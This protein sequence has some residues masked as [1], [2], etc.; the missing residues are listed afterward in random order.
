[1]AD[2]AAEA[3]ERD[4]LAR[5]GDLSLEQLL[6]VHADLELTDIEEPRRVKPHV[7]KVILRHLSSEAVE[8]SAD[9]G[10]GFFLQIQ[11]YINTLNIVKT[12]PGTVTAAAAPT[13]GAANA[14]ANAAAVVG[15]A[16]A[17]VTTST[18]TNVST[19]ATSVTS[20]TTTTASVRKIDLC[21]RYA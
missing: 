7:L 14:A 18:P 20:A 9:G 11:E 8:L 21:V 1:M 6:V 15:T 13:V 5:L 2:E 10:L 17:T 19:T 12:E 16:A 3:V 4:V